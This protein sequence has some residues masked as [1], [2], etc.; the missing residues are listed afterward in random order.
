[1][2]S[3]IL[4]KIILFFL[5]IPY[6]SLIAEGTFYQVKAE[7]WLY[8]R[9]TASQSG[10][11]EKLLASGSIVRLIDSSNPVISLNKKKGKWIEVEYLGTKGFVFDYY[12]TSAKLLGSLI[13]YYTFLK[14]LNPSELSSVAKARSEFSKK[15]SPK[16][17]ES[18]S[19]FRLFREF[20][21]S[22]ISLLDNQYRQKLSDAYGDFQ[23]ATIQELN[24][25]GISAS[26]CEGDFEFIEYLPFYVE[27]LKPYNFPLK[28]SLELISEAGGSYACDAGIHI[29]WEEMRKRITKIEAFLVKQPR[30]PETFELEET[31]HSLMSDYVLGMDNTPICDFQTNVV[32]DEINLSYQLFEKENT[33]S[34]YFPFFIKYRTML[35]ENKNKCSDKI[36]TFAYNNFHK[37]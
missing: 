9:A 4:F 36:R 18:E 30:S 25:N 27:I 31:L 5:L 23:N 17:S 16:S 35:K 1:M 3:K 11:V 32:I 2:Y 13:S 20:M 26:F 6:S 22:A 24:K 8:L 28:K 10:S 29:S 7:N 12:L 34:K 33:K 37:N 21:L 15:F 19:A 14:K